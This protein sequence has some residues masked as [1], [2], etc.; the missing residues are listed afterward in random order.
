MTAEIDNKMGD[1]HF[2]IRNQSQQA[3]LQTVGL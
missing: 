3:L 2:A 1:L